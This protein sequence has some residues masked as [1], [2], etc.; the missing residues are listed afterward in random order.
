MKKTNRT[1]KRFAAITSASLLAAC[2]V[3]PMA[4]MNVSAFNV[5]ISNSSD[6]TSTGTN[7]DAGTHTYVAYQIFKGN[8]SGGVLS[9]IEWGDNVNN[10]TGLINALKSVPGF[11]GLPNNA[12]AKDVAG[13]L[14]AEGNNGKDSDV[15]KAFAK[16][17]AGY[18]KG[19]PTSSSNGVI[20]GL[21]NGYYLI[22]D[23]SNPSL[24]A[25]NNSGAQTR[26]ILAV[27]GEDTTVY[28]KNDAP[29]VVKKV[30]ENKK[31]VSDY[32][33]TTEP[34]YDSG[35]F[36]DEYNDVA[37]YNI[38]DDVPFMLEATMPSNIGDYSAYYLKFTDT[39]ANGFTAPAATEIKIYVDG[40]EKTTSVYN[41]HKDISGQV[42]TITIED[43]KALGAVAGS[44]VTVK[45]NAELNA[46]ANIGST[47]NENSVTL[48]YSSN[49]NIEWKPKTDGPNTGETE[50]EAGT[51]P[52][53][54]NDNLTDNPNTPNID[55]S[56]GDNTGDTPEDKVVVYTYE[57]DIT[58]YLDTEV[59]GKEEKTGAAGFKL[60]NSE[61]KAAVIKNNKIDS[62]VTESPESGSV[63]N[64]DYVAAVNGTEIFT[65][66]D[67]KVKFV[68]LD[69]G[70][71]TLK[72]TTTPD[73]YNTMDDLTIIVAATTANG[74]NWTGTS[75][76]VDLDL[77]KSETEYLDGNAAVGDNTDGILNYGIVNVKGNSLPGT[78]GIGTTIFYLGGGAMA[79]IG[80]IYLISKRRMKK[81]EE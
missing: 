8:Y 3:A 9:N 14:S 46:G 21:N 71:Y 36:Y 68:G 18:V 39:L 72:E 37:D 41:V 13:I 69:D 29:S 77:K 73:T 54:P 42:I 11:T 33:D 7:N 57:L 43:V 19:T 32:L 50:S 64:G 66:T 35:D 49:P 31:D 10:T 65:G 55:E 56:Q 22:E 62:W 59:A 61:G 47:G 1:F 5:T 52:E 74:Q 26:F 24:G 34:T 75:A 81:S 78:G 45:Y 27:L 63:E 12:T 38:G 15:A 17:I 79:A 23:S 28:T 30:Q 44:K 53:T 48:E 6:G 76:L 60:Y 51:T 20:S 16:F 25:G 2:M 58:K 70:T 67:G 40:L 4:S 80:G